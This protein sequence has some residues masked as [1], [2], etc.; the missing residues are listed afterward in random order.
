MKYKVV[1]HLGVLYEGDS[2]QDARIAVMSC[3]EVE[4][5]FGYNYWQTENRKGYGVWEHGSYQEEGWW[6][7]SI[8]IPY[9]SKMSRNWCCICEQDI[10]KFIEIQ[11]E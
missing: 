3:I 9:R 7:K 5:C 2:L 10:C 11:E 6:D 4:A 8:P 1:S